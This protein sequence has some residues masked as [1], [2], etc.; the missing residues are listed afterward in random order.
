[1]TTDI[2]PLRFVKEKFTVQHM[3]TRKEHHGEDEEKGEDIKFVGRMANAVLDKF[4]PDLRA[5]F[6]VSHR[7]QAEVAGT[8]STPT[9]VLTQIKKVT[10]VEPLQNVSLRVHDVDSSDDDAVLVGGKIKQ[11]VF[12][13]MDGGTVEVTFTA[14][15]SVPEEDEIIKVRRVLFQSVPVSLEIPEIE[16]KADNFQQ[17]DLLGQQPHSEARQEAESLFNAPPLEIKDVV[18][19]WAGQDAAPAA[20][21]EPKV[22]DIAARRGRKKSDV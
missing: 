3:N 5:A 12:E 4:H 10:W 17:A 13:M 9:R 18:E 22:A 7:Q 20:A 6:Y 1:M 21:P 2:E 16:A 14:S 19:T 15:F 8:E 11:F